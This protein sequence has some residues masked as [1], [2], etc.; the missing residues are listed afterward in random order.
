MSQSQ[1]AVH[2]SEIDIT[3][4]PTKSVTFAPNTATVTRE[5]EGIQ[6]KSGANEITILGL[7]PNI[8]PDSVRVEGYGL[9]TITD[10]Q[11]ETIPRKQQ[12]EDQYPDLVEENDLDSDDDS[13]LSDD[14]Y[15]VDKS[16]VNTAKSELQAAEQTL[17]GFQNSQDTAVKVLG[18]LDHYG[19]SINPEEVDV[20]KMSDFLNV[21]REQRTLESKTYQASSTDIILWTEKVSSAREKFNRAEAAFRKARDA[22]SRDI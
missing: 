6:I 18:F 15:G 10:I 14:D 16:A 8:D 17:A 4:L 22:A 21:Y 7:D 2:T 1:V 9:A 12:F 20:A 3:N 19:E 11:T 13:K 5:I